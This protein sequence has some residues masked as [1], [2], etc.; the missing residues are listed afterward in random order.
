MNCLPTWLRLACAHRVMR[1][2]SGVMDPAMAKLLAR[3]REGATWSTRWR[4]WGCGR[5]LVRKAGWSPPVEMLVPDQVERIWP[6]PNTRPQVMD[7]M[8]Y[9]ILHHLMQQELR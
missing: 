1:R 8:K 5:E 7:P 6:T 9:K 3:D 2:V 4:C